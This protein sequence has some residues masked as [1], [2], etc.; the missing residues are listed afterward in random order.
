MAILAITTLCKEHEN[1]RRRAAGRKQPIEVQRLDGVIGELNLRWD[2]GER[3]I[4][5]YQYAEI[6]ERQ[7][8]NHKLRVEIASLQAASI[9]RS[10]ILSLTSQLIGSAAPTLM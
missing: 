7:R 4:L 5:D 9:L 1:Q 3:T 8:A 6:L 2:R 10:Q